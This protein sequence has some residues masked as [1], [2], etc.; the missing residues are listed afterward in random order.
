MINRRE[1]RN[2]EQELKIKKQIEELAKVYLAA[3][4]GIKAELRRL[5]ITDFRRARSEAILREINLIL[6]GLDLK[7]RQ[8]AEKA[9]PQ[10]YRRGFDLAGEQLKRLRVTS[11]V[12]YDKIIHTSAV[13][14]LV[15]DITFDLLF[16]ND[17]IQK[18]V[19]R[20]IRVT[21]QRIMEDQQISRM[22]AEGVVR[23]ETRRA[24]SDSLLEAFR[25]RMEDEQF[26][27]INGRNYRPDYYAELVA[28]TRGREASSQGTI[29]T[30]LQ[31]DVDLVQWSVHSNSCPICQELQGKIYSISGTNDDFPALTKETTPP[32]HPHCAHVLTPV[33][34]EVLKKRGQYDGLSRFSKGEATKAENFKQFMELIS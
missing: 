21:Q 12:D 17:S 5:D 18:N 8:W 30:A 3:Q 7:A 34:S 29:N 20:F 31:Y 14:I 32:A 22:I 25:K 33:L 2:I 6:R 19:G 26:I 4:K 9:I 15:D 11:F 28:R 24:V 16:A 1:F 10:A 27:T 23:G 13:G